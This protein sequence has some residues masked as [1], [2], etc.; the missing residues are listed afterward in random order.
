VTERLENPVRTGMNALLAAVITLVPATVL[1]QPSQ[2]GREHPRVKRVLAAEA[3]LVV[4]GQAWYYRH[5]R[6]TNAGDW[7]LPMTWGTIAQKLTGSGFRFDGDG[8]DTN[9]LGHPI[10]GLTAYEVG[11]E[12]GLGM[13]GSFALATLD[14]G[15]WE[16]F[17]EWREYGS[18]ND[19]LMTS[20]AGVPLGETLHQ[21][22]HH[23]DLAAIE[24]MASGGRV[25]ATAVEG[26]SMAA[27]I[28]APSVRHVSIAFDMPFDAAGS[29]GRQVE[30]RAELFD[31]RLVT[32]FDYRLKWER[33]NEMWD[34]A[35]LVGLGP[36]AETVQQVGDTRIVV[37]VDA[38]L[39][40]GMV[41]PLAFD[42]WRA[43]HPSDFVRGSLQFN[44]HGYYHGIGAVLAP[45]IEITRGPISGGVRASAGIYRA[46]NGHD[47]YEQMIT[48]DPAMSDREANVA[49]WVGT[50]AGPA[51]LRF[52]VS[53]RDRH[54]DADQFSASAA[55]SSVRVMAGVRL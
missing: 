25:G 7:E 22:I 30:A 34:L 10:F 20:T 8:F 55:E 13:F 9:A 54:G 45:R 18:I 37:G 52:E 19:M 40:S 35:A 11:R 14:S 12:N 4:L 42:A 29:R 48:A 43:M 16:T 26:V 39:V 49:A 33:P 27:Q 47:R 15:L 21:L 23:H 41:R 44:Q 17:G 38:E 5:G 6:L 51:V 46:L 36:T 31:R 32:T 3:A 1:A 28:A 2:E 24:V 53:H 50:Q